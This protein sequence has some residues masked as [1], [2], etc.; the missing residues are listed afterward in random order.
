MNEQKP[1]LPP[2]DARTVNPG[3]SVGYHKPLSKEVTAEELRREFSQLKGSNGVVPDLKS[4]D[5]EALARE[6]NGLDKRNVEGWSPP[7]APGGWREREREASVAKY[8]NAQMSLTAMVSCSIENDGR[9]W[10]HLSVSHRTRIP[11]WG[12]LVVCKESFL[13]DREAYQVMP[14]RARY[15]SI[16]PYVLN[17]FALLND[18]AV[19]PD[20]T[21][22]TGGI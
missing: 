5:F 10:L 16:H 13:G 21:R 4:V 15:V 1:F 6:A 20:F 8:V 19:L 14:P 22:A 9:A 2:G 18:E 3:E 12:E 11:T 7:A 17:V